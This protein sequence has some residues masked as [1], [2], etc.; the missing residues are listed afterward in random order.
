MCTSGLR[1]WVPLLAPY[2]LG[3][4]MIQAINPATQ[5]LIPRLLSGQQ[6]AG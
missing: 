3:Q 2:S 6:C 5:R 1:F 4:L